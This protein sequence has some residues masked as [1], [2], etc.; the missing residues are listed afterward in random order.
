MSFLENVDV[1]DKVWVMRKDELG[2]EHFETDI[3]LRKLKTKICTKSGGE[4][5]AENGELLSGNSSKLVEYNEDIRKYVLDR[6]LYHVLSS[7]K[8]IEF[9][10][11]DM[12]EGF[13]KKIE[14]LYEANKGTK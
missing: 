3:I 7:I 8:Y 14:N 5:S 4:Y 10:S 12:L 9:K 13:V 6:R 1:G 2:S 11:N